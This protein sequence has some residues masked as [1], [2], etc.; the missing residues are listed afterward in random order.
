MAP[1]AKNGARGPKLAEQSADGRPEDEADAEG[2][3]HE[4]EALRALAGSADVGDVGVS[5]R[6][7]GAG[8]ARD[9]A[10]DEQ[11]ADR[12]REPHDEVV[13][14]ERQQREQQHRP[15]AEVHR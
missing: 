1:A 8:D 5:G 9:R 4:A 12:R 14:A 3:A 15:A 10:P 13:T 11:P 2:R 7:R 6:E